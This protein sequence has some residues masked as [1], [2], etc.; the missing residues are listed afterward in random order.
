[1]QFPMLLLPLVLVA[2]TAQPADS[3]VQ[4]AP[5]SVA[6]VSAKYYNLRAAGVSNFG[7]DVAVDWP[8]VF[9]SVGSDVPADNPT[10]VELQGIH[11][12]FKDTLST[13]PLIV[14]D[15]KAPPN[16]DT[17]QPIAQMKSGF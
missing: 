9:H 2:Q 15:D 8:S 4:S 16:A 12:S 10:L 14:W 1:M 17:E 6:A 11:I 7:C 13:K 3:T 5:P